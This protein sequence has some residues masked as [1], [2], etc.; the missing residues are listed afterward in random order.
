MDSGMMPTIRLEVDNMKAAIM[1]H[2]GLR[3]D[4]YAKAIDEAIT[5]Q[6]IEFDFEGELKRVMNKVVAEEIHNYFSYG[7]GNQA[8]REG[9]REAIETQRKR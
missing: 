1:H 9:V 7:P 5:K 4:D 8:I 2:M 3:N 6:L